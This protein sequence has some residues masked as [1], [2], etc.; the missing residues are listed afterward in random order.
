[1]CGLGDKPCG[2]ALRIFTSCDPDAKAIKAFWIACR[3]LR[4]ADESN[5]SQD[6]AIVEAPI[7]TPDQITISRSG[8]RHMVLSC[9]TLC[10]FLTTPKGG[11]GET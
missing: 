2:E 10:C 9:P 8:W 11:Y 7:P 6:A 3:A 5:M 1:M 4:T